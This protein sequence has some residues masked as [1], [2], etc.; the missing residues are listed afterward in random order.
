MQKFELHIDIES[1]QSTVVAEISKHC[2]VNQ[3][4]LSNAQIKQAITKGA[5]WLS[6]GKSTLRLRKVKKQLAPLD[7]LH[8][9]FD[10]K[11]LAQTPDKA[12]LIQDLHDYSIWY[13]PY[14][15]LSQ[16]SK[17]SDHC[18]IAR[19]AET[20]LTPQRPAFIVHRLDRAASGLIIIAHSKKAAQGFSRIFEQ[21]Q[22]DKYYQVIV[23]GQLNSENDSSNPIIIES[24]IDDK[25]A[26][27]IVSILDYH[28][29][30]NTS[31]LQVKIETGR[32]HQIRK[33]VASINYPVVGDRLHGNQSINYPDNLNLQLCAVSLAFGCPLSNEHKN[34]DLPDELKP[35]ISLTAKKLALIN[36]NEPG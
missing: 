24:D 26:K 34:F 23:H 1:S 14:G 35:S 11:V 18:T 22:L 4:S 33:H 2:Q 36:K 10:E 17:W 13:K 6:R 12:V 19:W 21:H 29:E 30:S 5:L 8:F 25:S 32:K 15:M 3:Y 7:K 28:P 16:G 20:Q 9:Y 27:S 31:L